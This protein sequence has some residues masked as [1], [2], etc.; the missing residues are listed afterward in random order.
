MPPQIGPS[1]YS[2]NAKLV[3]MLRIMWQC[4]LWK[5]AQYSHVNMVLCC[6]IMG[7]VA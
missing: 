7:P 4:L 1:A 3:S 2:S 5:W 6:E